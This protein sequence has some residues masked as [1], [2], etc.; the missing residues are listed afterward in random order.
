ME[1][2]LEVGRKVGRGQG[3]VDGRAGDEGLATD[4]EE[5]VVG[6]EGTLG[7]AEGFGPR[8]FL[9]GGVGALVGLW[10][11][12]SEREVVLEAVVAASM[13]VLVASTG[14]TMRGV[15][16]GICMLFNEVLLRSLRRTVR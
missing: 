3:M 12:D 7:L 16:M 9:L 13:A 1:D 8:P 10:V 2:E 6:G 5:E 14:W 15:E 4:A 11:V